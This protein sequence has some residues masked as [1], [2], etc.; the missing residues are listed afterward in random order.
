MLRG[1][2][3][4]INRADSQAPPPHAQ[5]KPTGRTRRRSQALSRFELIDFPDPIPYPVIETS[6]S[7]QAAMARTL[8][9][10]NMRLLATIIIPL[11]LASCVQRGDDVALEPGKVSPPAAYSTRA[12]DKP[13]VRTWADFDAYRP[14]A[15]EEFHLV[16]W[17]GLRAVPGRSIAIR[18]SEGSRL[19][20]TTAHP[21]YFE[22]WLQIPENIQLGHTYH[23]RRAS[24]RR[25]ISRT[26]NRGYGSGNYSLLKDGEMTLS[27][28]Q[29]YDVPTLR[30]TRR[31]IATITV[32]RISDKSIV[33]HL[34]GQMPVVEDMGEPLHYNVNVDRTYEAQ[35][36]PIKAN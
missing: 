20:N 12:G 29:G 5:K 4:L 28:M 27:G 3:R 35:F 15:V 7:D 1:L 33:F 23:L 36:K 31:P 16:N 34:H 14:A 9:L 11:S 32:K 21:Q 25:E 10:R 22:L 18:L 8:A 2:H 24:D 6:P 30:R 26:E 17:D 13:F 19:V